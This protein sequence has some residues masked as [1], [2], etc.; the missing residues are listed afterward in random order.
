[1]KK[2][3]F[4][5]SAMSMTA[6][7]S[8]G[9]TAATAFFAFVFVL[10]PFGFSVHAFGSCRCEVGGAA[11]Q[12]PVCN[13]TAYGAKGDGK[14]KDTTAIQKALDA[15]A[16]KSGR[17]VV[18]P[19][20]YLTGSLYLGDDTELHLEEGAVILG[21]PDLADYN[22]P[23]AY[24]QNHGSVKEGWSAKHLIL[25]LEKKNVKITGKGTIDGNGRAFF[26]DRIAYR[27]HVCWRHGARNAKGKPAEQLRPGQEIVFIE[28]S[29]IEVRDVTFRDMSCWSCFNL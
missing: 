5:G 29:G 2:K 10:L 7:A 4:L 25:A 8:I 26:A 21:S 24:P 11:L 23:D 18:P 28:C 19:G 17:V 9:R 3:M 16:G 20:T 15:C 1:M 27:H 6:K 22:A 12:A 13:V 14:T